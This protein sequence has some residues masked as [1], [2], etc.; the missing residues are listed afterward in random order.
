MEAE[1]MASAATPD[2]PSTLHRATLTLHSCTNDFTNSQIQFTFDRD[3]VSRL[4]V[5]EG[6]RP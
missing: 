4:G 3:L 1:S 6:P 2:V 5:K